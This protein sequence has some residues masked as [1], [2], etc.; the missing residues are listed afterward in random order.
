[1]VTSLAVLSVHG[2]NHFNTHPVKK[3][4]N[5]SGSAVAIGVKNLCERPVI[6]FAGPKDELSKPEP[7][8]RVFEGHSNKTL[9]V[10]IN[11]MV[12]IMHES[13]KSISCA[14]VM[15]GAA[16]MEIDEGGT[17]ITIK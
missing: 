7:R 2:Q 10:S 15:G 8:Q 3:P 1:M 4:T 11:E 14:D 16:E 12:C 17:T 13:G 5:S 6:I 9:Y